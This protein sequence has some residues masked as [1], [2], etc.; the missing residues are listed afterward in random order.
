MQVKVSKALSAF[1]G[2]S[3]AGADVENVKPVE[4]GLTGHRYLSEAAAA[5][6]KHWPC[7]HLHEEQLGWL[8]QDA[9]LALPGPL[10]P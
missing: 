2:C 5:S 8:V 6:P 9:C 3:V 4:P 1:P 7:S 10:R